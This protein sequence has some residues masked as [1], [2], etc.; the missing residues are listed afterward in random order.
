MSTQATLT[1]A[2]ILT[3]LVEPNRPTIS[4]QLAEELLSLR[5]KDEATSRIRDLLQKNNAGTITSAEKATLENYLRV[6]EFLDL[7]QAKARITLHQN[8]SAA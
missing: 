2:D 6:G 7:M 1:E 4:P 3:E 8:G 5:F